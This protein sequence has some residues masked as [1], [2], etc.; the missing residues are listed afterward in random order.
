VAPKLQA[1][2]ELRMY[3]PRE[4]THTPLAMIRAVRHD[5]GAVVTPA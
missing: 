3:L 5:H 4:G 2:R 1:L